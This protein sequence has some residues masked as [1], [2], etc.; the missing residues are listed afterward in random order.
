MILNLTKDISLGRF[1]KGDHVGFD[2]V[3][4]VSDTPSSAIPRL[5]SYPNIRV[6]SLKGEKYSYIPS[7]AL[8][9]VETK[10]LTEIV[11]V[12][13]L[14]DRAASKEILFVPPSG[15]KHLD[16]YLFFKGERVKDYAK[17]PPREK[18][19]RVLC[20][21]LIYQDTKNPNTLVWDGVYFTQKGTMLR[22]KSLSCAVD[23][24]NEV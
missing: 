18:A 5:I 9:F 12:Q 22:A 14:L 8:R 15:R 6:C 3:H 16:M 24:F 13:E 2:L 11:M 19:L 20:Y 10:N 23:I 17:L 21:D 4:F 7:T 1:A